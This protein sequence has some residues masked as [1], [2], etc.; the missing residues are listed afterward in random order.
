[1]LASQ[2]APTSASIG[3]AFHAG[4]LLVAG[5]LTLLTQADGEKPGIALALNPFGTIQYSRFADAADA[6]F[7]SPNGS[8]KRP[9]ATK[10]N[11]PRH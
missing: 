11:G 8:S 10:K 2:T 4:F 9:R 3:G 6:I 5:L 1:M 7:S